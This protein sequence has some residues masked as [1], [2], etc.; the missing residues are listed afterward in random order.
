M[1]S[2]MS[3]STAYEDCFVADSF[4][5]GV[6]REMNGDTDG[7]AADPTNPSITDGT[8]NTFMV[9]E[10]LPTP[11]VQK[12]TWLMDATFQGGVTVATDNGPD[13]TTDRH[14]NYTYDFYDTLL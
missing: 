9:G 7:L 2:A 10:I 1:E 3:R 4:S 6:E 8:S 11:D 13:A 5:F 12:G 14:I